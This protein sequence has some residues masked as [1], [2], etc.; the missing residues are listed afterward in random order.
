M[1]GLDVIEIDGGSLSL[2]NAISAARGDLVLSLSNG[3]RERVDEARLFIESIIDDG[4]ST[5]GVN[6]G[7]GDLCNTPISDD[8][9]EDLQVNLVRSHACGLGD[10]MHPEDVMLM[11]A[12]RANSLASGHSGIRSGVIDTLLTCIS[13]GIAPRVPRIGSLGASGDL[14]PLAHVALGLIGE[15]EAYIRMDSDRS[16]GEFDGWRRTKMDGAMALSGIQPVRLLAKEGLSLINGTSQM[17]AWL[18]LSLIASE[19]L[20]I[21]ADAAL[22]TSIEAVKGS[23]KPFH[24][25]IHAARPHTGQS[26]SASRV[27]NHLEGSQNIASHADCEKVQ[28]AYAFRCGAQ[29]HGP[30]IERLSNTRRILEIE[31]N[32][33]TDN[34]LVV[35]EGEQREVISGGNFHGEILALAADD[36]ALCMHEIASI[37]ERR[38]DGVLDSSSSGLPPFLATEPGVENGMMILQY[39]S[40]A[41]LAEMRIYTTPATANNIP[42]SAGQEDHVSMGATAAWSALNNARLCAKIIAAELIVGCAA[43][44]LIPEKP[45]LGVAKVHA[46][47]RD[48]VPPMEGDRPLGEEIELVASALLSGA[49]NDVIGPS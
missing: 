42:V 36:M 16:H 47:I 18:S 15:G 10:P 21:A 4:V 7:F 6:T 33:A 27:R 40:A 24:P 32:S 35:G 2:E 8:S 28:D 23:E 20:T 17:C 9:L 49:L 11:M 43:I 41:V 19:N 25:G 3:A 37:S 12:F 22:A 30:V 46:W 45:G 1:I 44:D 26:E 5:Y 29:V 31:I 14:A 38:I 48:M 34:P 39:S 13:E